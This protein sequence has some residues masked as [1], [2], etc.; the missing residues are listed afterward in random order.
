MYVIKA[1]YDGTDFKPKEPIPVNEEYEVV[2]TFTTPVKNSKRQSRYFSNTE[3]DAFRKSLF[4]V[5]PSN[6]DLDEAREE[7]LR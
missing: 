5:L 2:I 7:R 4:G 6:I 3:R 1:L